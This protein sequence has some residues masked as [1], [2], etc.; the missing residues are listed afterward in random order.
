[1]SSCIID[2]HFK[3]WEYDWK[4]SWSLQSKKF[5]PPMFCFLM[6][7]NFYGFNRKNL[8]QLE[9]FVQGFGVNSV[10]NNP[11]T[12]RA[13]FT[14]EGN[15]SI[16]ESFKLGRWGG[17][18]KCDPR[19]PCS[20]LCIAMASSSDIIQF[21]WTEIHTWAES[22]SKVEQIVGFFLP[23]LYKSYCRSKYQGK[24]NF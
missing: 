8:H 20:V 11:P 1:M 3:H 7:R 12:Y 16:G 19:L 4:K 14:H 2:P 24:W 10:V 15:D 21:A 22:S 18:I 9:S 5:T 17:A 13:F 23:G 6:C